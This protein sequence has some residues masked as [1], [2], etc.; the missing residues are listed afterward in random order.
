MVEGGEVDEGLE[1]RAD[2]AAALEGAV[3]FRLVGIPSAD[4]GEHGAGEVLDGDHTALKILRTG[5]GIDRQLLPRGAGLVR[6]AAGALDLAELGIERLFGLL[7][8]Q[9]IDGGGDLQPAELDVFLFQNPLQFAADG[10]HRVAVVEDPPPLRADGDGVLLRGFGGFA[11]DEFLQHH[12]V[13]DGVP[14]ADRL[15]DVVEGRERVRAADDAGEQRGFG[16]GQFL[17]ALFK[18]GPRR[19]LD[20]ADLVAPEDAVHVVLE[21]FLFVVVRLDPVGDGGFQQLAVELLQLRGEIEPLA[22]QQEA[23]PGEL[24]GQ[25]GGSLGGTGALD[26]LFHRAADA[27]PVD[28]T[29]AEEA[30]VLAGEDGVDEVQGDIFVADHVALFA[31]DPAEFLAAAVVDDGALRHFGHLRHVERAGADEIEDGHGEAG[32]EAGDGEVA[33]GPQRQAKCLGQGADE[34]VENV[35]RPEQDDRAETDGF[36]RRGLL[37]VGRALVGNFSGWAPWVLG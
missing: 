22:F 16:E 20:P 4:D 6:V 28:P 37:A 14:F 24:H 12:A 23:V 19:F 10:V 31:V 35:E 34:G 8:N 29:V 15:V 5:L 32:V 26:V 3:E 27:D 21:D 13:E 11:R 25:R 7:L 9:V 1:D 36:G 17:G 2:L 33:A 30:F 18:V